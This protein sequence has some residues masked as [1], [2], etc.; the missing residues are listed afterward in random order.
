MQTSLE[1]TGSY[2]NDKLLV[3]SV[4]AE[5]LSKEIWK[6]GGKKKKKYMVNFQYD[7]KYSSDWE[8]KGEED[9]EVEEVEEDGDAG[10]TDESAAITFKVSP[11]HKSKALPGPPI[12]PAPAASGPG[13]SVESTEK[14]SSI[15][16]SH[17]RERAGSGD[18]RGVARSSDAVAGGGGGGGGVGVGVGSRDSSSKSGSKSSKSSSRSRGVG[19]GGQDENVPSRE[20]DTSAADRRE[21]NFG[22]REGDDEDDLKAWTRQ[23]GAK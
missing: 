1:S 21:N 14:K 15:G 17:A 6:K 10:D 23:E 12:P 22:A 20:N 11:T 9:A 16:S 18:G 19:G 8:E 5:A 4:Q 7:A 13:D 3:R 2:D